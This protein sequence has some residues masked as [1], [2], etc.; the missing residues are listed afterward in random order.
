MM[1]VQPFGMQIEGLGH[2]LVSDD[3]TER[4]RAALLLGEVHCDSAL[5]EYHVDLAPSAI[6]HKL[7]AGCCIGFS[8]SQCPVSSRPSCSVP[9]F[10]TSRLVSLGYYIIVGLPL[11]GR[12]INLTN[13]I[14]QCFAQAFSAWLLEGHCWPHKQ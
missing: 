10:E 7:H 3:E 13:I 12:F 1:R 6:E 4:G 5:T 2:S 11:L 8:L 14:V 9:V